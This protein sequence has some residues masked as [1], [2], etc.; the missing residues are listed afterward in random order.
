MDTATEDAAVAIN[1]A[2]LSVNRHAQALLAADKVRSCDAW[3][4]ML[5]YPTEFVEEEKCLL[6]AQIA[7]DRAEAAISRHEQAIADLTLYAAEAKSMLEAA[8]PDQDEN[9][10]LEDLFSEQIDVLAEDFKYQLL[11]ELYYVKRDF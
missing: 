3:R 5:E 2:E 4:D 8:V 1:D 9:Y 10:G 7:V 6:Q 11:Y